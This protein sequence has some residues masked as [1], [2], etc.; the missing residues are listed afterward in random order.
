MQPSAYDAARISPPEQLNR[1][2]APRQAIP[3][4][5]PLHLARRAGPVTPTS[6]HD[7]RRLKRAATTS[8]TRGVR[9]LARRCPALPR[10]HQLLE[11]S[12]ARRDFYVDGCGLVDG[13][14]TTPQETQSGVAFG[15]DAARWDAWILVGAIGFDGGAIDLLEWQEPAPTG[16][17]LT[18]L[19]EAGLPAHRSAVPDLDARDREATARGG[20]VWSEPLVHDIPGGG[21]CAS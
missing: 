4:S 16:A 20:T 8:V 1:P 3:P 18:A 10:Q 12:R 14:R 19:Y 2:P 17:A 6:A 11:L 21:A 7:G 9:T 13:V 5:D 15:L